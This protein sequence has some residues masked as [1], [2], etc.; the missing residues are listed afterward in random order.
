MGVGDV[1]PRDQQ[2]VTPTELDA[3]RCGQVTTSVGGGETVTLM[4][5][6]DGVTGRYLIVQ[7]R[8]RHE[9]LTLCEVEAG[10]VMVIH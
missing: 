2:D 7:I 5:P 3:R 1:E 9:Y 4:C 8:G 6:Q 10:K